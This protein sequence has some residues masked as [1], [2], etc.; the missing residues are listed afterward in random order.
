MSSL[1]GI[2]LITTWSSPGNAIQINDRLFERGRGL[3]LISTDILLGI[4]V[5]LYMRWSVYMTM[6]TTLP[7]YIQQIPLSPRHIWYQVR[8]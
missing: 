1:H 5:L 3:M 4:N 7:E 2:S 6:Q 8:Y